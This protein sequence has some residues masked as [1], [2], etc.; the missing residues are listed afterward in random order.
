MTRLGDALLT[1]AVIVAGVYLVG[2]EAIQRAK[3]VRVWFRRKNTSEG[4]RSPS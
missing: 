2:W 3:R 1:G 4:R